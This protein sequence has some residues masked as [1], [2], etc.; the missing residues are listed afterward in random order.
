MEKKLLETEE[1]SSCFKPLTYDQL[2]SERLLQ[3]DFKKQQQHT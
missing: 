2:L 1:P 3:N